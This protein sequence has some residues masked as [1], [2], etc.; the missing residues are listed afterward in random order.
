MKNVFAALA[1]MFVAT[2][3][4]AELWSLNYISKVK[5]LSVVLN[6]NAKDA[7]W[8]N[9]TETREY[10][11]EKVRMAG[12]TLY[13]TGEKYFGEYYALRVSVNGHRLSN[14]Q[15]FGYVDVTLGTPTEINGE[16][17]IATHR[18]RSNYF[19]GM[20]NANQFIIG[21]VQ[22]FFEGD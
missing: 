22:S 2:S 19:G 21:L 18:S 7:C 4:S 8:T 11:E 12:G 9:L 6:D 14:G 15:C 17:H 16:R 20:Q 1:L 5:H 10:A 13:E 3:S